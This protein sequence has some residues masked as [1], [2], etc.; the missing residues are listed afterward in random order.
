MLCFNLSR[1]LGWQPKAG[2]SHLDSMLRGEL[3]TALAVFGHD[4]TLNEAIR[5]FH[6]FLE[7]KNM[8]L[9]PPDTRKVSECKA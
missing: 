4:L 1:K 6:V 8:P 2:E 3:L 9:L 5:R 7:D